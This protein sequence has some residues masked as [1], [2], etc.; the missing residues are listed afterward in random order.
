[1][2]RQKDKVLQQKSIIKERQEETKAVIN[3]LPHPYMKEID[4][5]DHLISYLN[6]MKVKMGLTVD[7]ELAARQAQAAIQQE[8]VQEKLNEK[9][10]AG[11]VEVSI[12]KQEREAASVIQIG[13]QKKNKG[14]KRKQAVEY[15]EFQIDFVIIKKFAT[16]SIAAPVNADDLDKSLAQVEEKKKWYEAN[17]GIKLQEQ[18]EELKRAAAEEEKFFEEETS[19]L[20][21]EPPTR[22]RGRGGRGAGYRGGRGGT[23]R[24]RG[25]G[26]ALANYQVRNEFDGDDEDE[27]VYSAPANKPKKN[28]QKQEDLQMDEENYPAL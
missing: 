16:L 1:M 15:E 7:N 9:L 23:S 26:G 22:G 5:C 2:Q 28:K 20:V 24:G 21:E 11:K 13:G 6:S 27:F 8:A 14:K 10:A 17:G 25:R 18:I 3:S 12:S 19:A 4:C